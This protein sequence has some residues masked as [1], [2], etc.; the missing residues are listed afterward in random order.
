MGDCQDSVGSYKI[1]CQERV[2]RIMLAHKWVIF[3][4]V[5]PHNRSVCQDSVGLK[6][7]IARIVLTN[8]SGRLL[9]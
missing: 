4:I 9:V 6:R 2:V 7:V 5:L 1:H 8:I 3:R